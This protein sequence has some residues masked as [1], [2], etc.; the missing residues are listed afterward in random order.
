MV[1]VEPFDSEE[2]AVHRANDS[3]FGLAASVW[4]RDLAKANR[5]ARRIEAGM[6]WVNDFGYSFTTGQ[7]AWGGVK[8]SGFLKYFGS[9]SRRFSVSLSRLRQL[10]ATMRHSNGR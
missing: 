3:E 6:V 7:A 10:H 5:V 4:S 1:S 9:I 2:E 8:S